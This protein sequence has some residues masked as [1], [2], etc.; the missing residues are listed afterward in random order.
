MAIIQTVKS[1]RSI[2][3][4]AAL[5]IASDARAGLNEIDKAA[6]DLSAS[7]A[8][9]FSMALVDRNGINW[10]GARGYADI[11]NQRP[12]TV[13]AVQNIASISKTFTATAL[14]L[15]VE[16]GKLDLDRDVND[17]LPFRV[18]DARYPGKMITARQLLTHSS[19]IIDREALYFSESSYHPGGDNPVALGEFLQTYLSPEGKH[20][21]AGNFASYPPGTQYQYSS[22]GFGLAG[23]LVEAL[24]GVPLN[25]FSA[26]K[27]FKPL[28][29]FASGWMLTEIDPDQHAKLYEWAH[30]KQVPV[31]WYGLVTWPDGGV[32]TSTRDLASFYAAMIG[33]GEFKGA[34]IMQKA[35]YE[36]MFSP[37][38][39]PG[40]PL[41]AV[42]EE[43]GHRQAIG[44]TY[45]T[46]KSG[47]TVVGHSGRD[48]GVST[49]A[50]FFPDAGVGAILLVNTSSQEE[51]FE[52]AVHNMI[53]V[54]LD[55]AIERAGQGSPLTGE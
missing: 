34:R 53:R 43:H 15:L 4:A 44:W 35:S 32:R 49:H 37:Q 8:A 23:Y 33:K 26:E 13:D 22:I 45:R 24:T 16:Q 31:E 28:A 11:E 2:F 51:E 46:R 20:Y 40:Q 50:W 6:Q 1:V 3:L 25:Q 14:M 5:F 54:L 19:S 39:I 9:G 29:M 36:A 52:Q 48:P 42:A 12:M 7:G 27:I 21:E 30:G 55:S 18:V 47:E 41:E 10:S 17:Y 38:F